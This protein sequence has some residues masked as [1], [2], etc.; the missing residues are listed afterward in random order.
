MIRRSD[1]HAMSNLIVHGGTPLSGRIVPS[2]NKNA[3]LPILCAT[4]LTKEPV[5]LVGI[6]EITDVKKILEIF[7]QL[8][9]TVSVDYAT[10]IL[11][12]HV[13]VAY[14]PGSAPA[15]TPP[16]AIHH[17]PL[18]SELPRLGPPARFEQIGDTQ[19][20]GSHHLTAEPREQITVSGTVGVNITVGN[21]SYAN[22]APELMV[23]P[24]RST[25]VWSTGGTG[26][27]S[28]VEVFLRPAGGGASRTLG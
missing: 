28:T 6:P 1:N 27:I 12:V 4:L 10:G 14:P 7:R 25:E 3:V 24:V 13:E 5:R 2:A 8:G 19:V 18:H 22:W 9:S 26:G 20:G 15:Y 21:D 23:F 16:S 17:F 11:D